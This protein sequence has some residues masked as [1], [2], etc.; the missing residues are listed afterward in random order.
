MPPDGQTA[1]IKAVDFFAV[2]AN[3]PKDAVHKQSHG[4]WIH[5]F[6]CINF[7]ILCHYQV[8]EIALL[9]SQI[10]T[11]T[12][13]TFVLRFVMWHMQQSA[14]TFATVCYANCYSNSFSAS[15]VYGSINQ[16]DGLF[17]LI[18]FAVL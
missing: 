17:M 18:Y 9:T 7:P 10:S 3:V 16:D 1:M 15:V 13:C 4:S 12:D 11:N 2:C 14:E 5:A 6:G 8:L